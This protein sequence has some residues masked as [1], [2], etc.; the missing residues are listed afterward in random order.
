[1]IFR[2]RRVPPEVRPPLETDER[3]VAWATVTEHAAV[4]AT[5]FG[6]HLPGRAVRLGWHE[7]HKA[8][9]TGRQLVVTPATLVAERSTYAVVADAAPLAVT[10]PEPGVL[11]HEVRTRVTRSV[12]FSSHQPVP[13]GAVRVVARRVPGVDGLRW[14]VRPDEGTDPFAPE[15]ERAA[16]ALVA[17]YAASVHDPSL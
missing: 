13:G 1:V 11:P 7:I 12:S 15:V 4:V 16:A 3:V 2:R 10:L 6:L 14:A 9:W 5:N 17:S 8:T